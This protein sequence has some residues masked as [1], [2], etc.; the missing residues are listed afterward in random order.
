MSHTDERGDFSARARSGTRAVSESLSA[1]YRPRDI[2]RP[3]AMR[4][5]RAGQGP[6]GPTAPPAAPIGYRCRPPEL[7]LESTRTLAALKIRNCDLDS[8]TRKELVRATVKVAIAERARA[9][10]RVCFPTISERTPGY[11]PVPRKEGEMKP[12]RGV[13]LL[14]S[15][16][17]RTIVRGVGGCWRG[18]LVSSTKPRN[19][20]GE[21]SRKH[22]AGPSRES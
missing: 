14:P 22:A 15:L 7:E 3:A 13:L 19:M 9:R 18:V 17:P 21:A 10:A 20:T 5:G 8:G 1:R 16:K 12:R 4:V 2:A 6:G 11:R